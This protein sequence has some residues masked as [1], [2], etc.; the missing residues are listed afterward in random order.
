MT[1]YEMRSSDW[2]SDVCS[3]DLLVQIVQP[4]NPAAIG[5]V[6]HHVAGRAVDAQPA[7][8]AGAGQGE[9]DFIVRLFRLAAGGA[10][11]QFLAQPRA[12]LFGPRGLFR[13]SN[14]KRFQEWRQI[15]SASWR[16]RVCQYVLIAVGA[17]CLTKT[18]QY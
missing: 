4:R 14:R 6:H 16:E 18:H 8:A 1:A 2:S 13:A 10:D 9:V 12:D 11:R 17:V 3:S 7:V 5:L 15:G